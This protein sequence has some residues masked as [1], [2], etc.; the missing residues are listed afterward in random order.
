VLT[1]PVLDSL[2]VTDSQAGLL[3]VQQRTPAAAVLYNQLVRFDLDPGVPTERIRSALADLARIQPALR[4]VFQ[5]L[6]QPHARL[7]EPGE[8]E[9]LE[10]R[11][12]AGQF[13][14]AV[15]D[16]AVRIGRAE[17]D[18]ARG[19]ACR[20]AVVRGEDA[21]ALLLCYHHIVLDGMSTGPLVADLQRLLTDPPAGQDLAD[22]QDR[23]ERAFAH[24]LR[25]QVRSGQAAGLAERSRDW[26]ARLRQVPPATLAP[27]PGRAS[28]PSFL[29][30]R[31]GWSLGEAEAA[32][33]DRLCRRLQLTPFV[34][35]TGVYST[36]VAR[37][38]GAGTVLIGSPFMARRTA[39]AFEL[40]GFFVNTLPVTVEVAWD[41]PFADHLDTVVRQAVDHCR[42]NVDIPFNRLVAD[43]RPDRGS[44]R[45]PLFSCMLA[46]QDGISIAPGGPLRGVGE[47]GNG[48]A[49]FDLWLG[50]TP[51]AGGWRLE[52]EYDR[53]LIGPGIADGLLGSLRTAVRLALADSSRTLAE[54]AEDAS[55]AASRHSDGWAGDEPPG[56]LLDWIVA[57]ADRLP[58]APAI[59][60]AGRRLT[61]RQLL[62]AAARVS[63]GLAARGIGPG[64]VVGLVSEDLGDTVLAMLAVLRRGA[65][66]LPLDA[67]LPLER[68]TYMA[69]RSGCRLV[70]GS[71]LVPSVPGAT[72][73]ELDSGDRP[74]TP[75][76][77]DPGRPVYVMFTSG[78]TGQPKGVLMGHGP[79]A[80]LTAWQLGALAMTA[81]TRFLQ[82]APLG[83]DVS[84]Q[85]IVPTLVAGGT[86]VS[87]A[88]PDRR[89]FPAL[90][91]RIADSRVSHLYLPATALR[92]IV[93]HAAGHGIRLP[94]L[95]FVCVSGEQLLVDD[96][97]ERFFTE[98]PHCQLVNLYGPTETHAVTSHR[99]SAR[100]AGWPGHV[101]IGLPYPNVFAYVVDVSGHLAPPGVPGELHL[102]GRCPAEG[103]LNDPEITAERFLP[104]R[105]AGTAGARMYRT[106]DLVVRDERDVLSYLGRV[107]SQVKIR[108]YRI[109]L[110]EIEST[111]NQVPSV[112]LSA[113]VARG[114]GADR[115]LVLFVVTEP[116]Q[117][118]DP[119]GIGSRLEQSLP[120]YMRPA[121]L[122]EIDRIPV[123]P[124][125]KT[126]RDALV[127]RA[128]ELLA[129]Q[130]VQ[131]AEQPA[132]YA[133][134][135][136]EQLAGLWSEALGVAGIVR[137]RP[138]L[139]Y[140]AHS[141]NILT[142]LAEVQQ[143]YGSPVPM[144]PFFASPTVATLA[145]LVR[146]G[147]SDQ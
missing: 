108:G 1:E 145:E 60:E 143:R 17:F 46:M 2:P 43:A 12:P 47:P 36:V 51:V 53:E 86:V 23:R 35:F 65:A 5:V 24:E 88:I 103:Y 70:I 34:F 39:G 114:S 129:A 71:P 41:R 78:S 73:R 20:F 25:A 132:G 128:D 21:S 52:L 97:I 144:V 6:P 93:Q 92:P 32:E 105:F 76:L 22:Q 138:L 80:N 49:K 125:G 9:L 131:A 124:T 82:Y 112:R 54:L 87:R 3:V 28:E 31:I 59:E 45:N 99:L 104:D 58:D 91:E 14:Q 11:A 140:G 10:H 16:A 98:H 111:A 26:A 118:F 7:A 50:V 64:D 42:R 83:F 94:A 8:P 120:A 130:A 146:A 67:G 84:F 139:E 77:A 85:E 37:H 61:Y 123:T 15:A 136:E 38:A 110:G 30:D 29:G 40:G 127:L 4:Q 66:F 134:E 18:L 75:S 19:P 147:R 102:G 133:D 56:A 48:S 57:T 109:E 62:A 55:V 119:A 106:G 79:L 142:V 96:E 115:E 141:L 122:H 81:E 100:D 63:D 13:E 90:V 44:N 117:Q 33:L 69:S 72:V 135:L 121:R 68:L 101:P 95:R 107:D 27:L 126:D 137:D 116:G 89:L 74:R 113:A